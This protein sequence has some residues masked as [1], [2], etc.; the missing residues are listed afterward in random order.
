MLRILVL[1]VIC[2]A[3][4]P[5]QAAE[6]V[7][8]NQLLNH[9]SPYLAMH[10]KDPVHWQTWSRETLHKARELNRPLLVS[11]GYFSCHWCHVMQRESYQDPELAQL[12]NE[13]FIPVKVDRELD[14]ALDA[15]LIE[16]VEL[17]QGQAGWPLNVLLTPDGYPVVGAVYL[18]RDRFHELLNHLQERW[19]NEPALLKGMARDAM[20]EWRQ[21][22]QRKPSALPASGSAARSLMIQTDQ[23]KDELGGG[24]GQQAK[25][26]M[27]PQLR[28]LLDVRVQQGIKSQDD[29]I[30]L[31]LD[32]MADQ[33]LRDVLGGGFFRYVTDPGWQVPHYE[34]MLYDNAQLAVL[35]LRAA[36][37][38]D[39]DYYR[40]VGLDT[41]DF[42]LREMLH[43][44]GYFIS[45]FSAVD[46][47]GREG[48]YYQWDQPTLEKLLDAEQLEA[49]RAAWFGGQSVHSGHDGLP[50]WQGQA[51]S[52]ARSLGWKVTKLE[53]A[54]AAAR[55]TMLATRS[56]RSLP[57]DS[58]GLAAWNGLA[59]SALAAGYETSS[60][61]RYRRHADRL[62]SWILTSLWD[63]NSL[64]RARDGKQVLAEATLEDYALV[65]QGL[66]DWQRAR[67]ADKTNGY[68]STIDQLIR[69]A[70]QNYFINKRWL[71]IDTP[72]IPMLEGR[73]ALDESSL[74]SASATIT[75]ISRHNAV[76]NKDKAIQDKVATHLQQVRSYLMDSMFWYASYVGL[77]ESD[78]SLR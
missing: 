43:A 35:Y 48:F 11:I 58:K 23:F 33:G 13:R 22:R 37:R 28:A 40:D 7:L 64:V 61:E 74:P 1:I 78:Q 32:R 15:H 53:R 54:L 44:D 4:G 36:D 5:S 21:L 30:R 60:D 59:L 56:R 75:R 72:L 42:M 16:F 45:S 50:R 19:K 9:P 29:F 52:I 62:A 65:A 12:L 24:F 57:A 39:S 2:L 77:L 46:D 41:L 71:Q 27:V 55:E 17:T 69:T 18:P 47:Q 26:P 38:Y 73:V 3:S 10:G 63:G 51:D 67:P 6:T 8:D 76:L 66:W 14:P 68:Q 34:K 49:V 20:D 70:W 31:T 25:F